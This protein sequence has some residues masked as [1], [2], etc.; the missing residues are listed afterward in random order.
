[1]RIR[2]E[3]AADWPELLNL[4][5]AVFGQ[6]AEADLVQRLHAD[7]ETILALTADDG[8]PMGHLVFSRLLVRETPHVRGCVLAPLVVAPPYQRQGVG[9]ALLE[10]GLSQLKNAGH[11][12]VVVLGDPAYY[13]RFG[14]S[15]ELARRL[16]TPYDGP[17][18]QALA[19]SEKG[20]EAHGPVAYADAFAEL[21]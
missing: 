17:Y 5:A 11:D 13:G 14:F 18:V 1:M 12:L 19:L 6:S 16:K 4:Y 10:E 2:P 15:A 9:S 20:Y 7:G 21:R 3:E 8:K